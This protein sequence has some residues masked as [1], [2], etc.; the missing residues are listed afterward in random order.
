MN[1]YDFIGASLDDRA[2][3]VWRWGTYLGGRTWGGYEIAL[4]YF[5]HFFAE[6]WLDRDEDR[7]IMIPAFKDYQCFSPYLDFI[8]LPQLFCS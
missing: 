5:D 3:F 6:V 1:L 7:I 4:F 8:E 2:A